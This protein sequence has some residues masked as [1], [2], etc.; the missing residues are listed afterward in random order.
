[1]PRSELALTIAQA[2]K[3]GLA[4]LLREA[5]FRDQGTSFYLLTE[6]SNRLVNVQSSQWNNSSR[7]RFTMNMGIYFPAIDAVMDG[8]WTKPGAKPWSSKIYNC[9]LW[10]RIGFLLPV[11]RDF[12]WEVTPHRS[13]AGSAHAPPS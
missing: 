6:E 11:Q 5:G 13:P 1:M 2:V 3:V 4:P 9:Q 10:K 7:S 8:V 12:W